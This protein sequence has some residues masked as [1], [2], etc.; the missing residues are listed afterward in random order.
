[1]VSDRDTVW[2]QCVRLGH[3]VLPLVDQEPWRLNKRHERLQAWNI[4]RG[5]GERLS[6]AFG[7]LT[8]HAVVSDEVAMGSPRT[9]AMLNGIPLTAALWPLRPPTSRTSNS[10]SMLL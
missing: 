9:I 10:A 7:T 6:A 4:D 1:M 3:H 8:L 2:R 5:K